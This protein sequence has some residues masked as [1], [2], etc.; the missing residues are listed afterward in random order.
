MNMP[1]KNHGGVFGRNPEF[2][3]VKAQSVEASTVDIDGGAIDGTAIGANNPDEVNGTVGRFIDQVFGVATALELRN[4]GA[5]NTAGRGS[6]IKFQHGAGG[7]YVESAAIRSKNGVNDNDRA[8]LAF[9]VANNGAPYESFELDYSGNA[10]IV[11]GNLVIGTSGK[12]IDFSATAGTGTSE[13]FDDYEE[14]AWTPVITDG[15]N[16]APMSVGAEGRYTKVGR[17]VH[18]YGRIRT[19]GLGSVSGN[20]LIGGLPFLVDN[21]TSGRSAGVVARASGLILGAAGQSLS[22]GGKDSE[23]QAFIWH[24]DDTSGQS[25]LQNTEWGA[26]GE[27]YIQYTYEVK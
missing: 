20:L 22:I 14:G 16:D 6:A 19:A 13:L 12:G 24:W 8:G 3:N 9:D 11:S 4:L 7:S 15:T 27:I 18:V 21:S 2:Q 1:I 25:V 5:N 17:I 26:N 10:K 23:A